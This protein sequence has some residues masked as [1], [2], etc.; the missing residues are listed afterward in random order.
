MIGIEQGPAVVGRSG[1]TPQEASV[2]PN[3]HP[4]EQVRPD[5]HVHPDA[6]PCAA[7]PARGFEPGAEPAVLAGPR[8]A[9]CHGTDVVLDEV[10][11][12]GVLL[13]AECRRCEHRWTSRARPA[14][15]RPRRVAARAGRRAPAAGGAPSGGAASAA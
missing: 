1:G 6:Q 9:V 13:L 11:H 5:P 14:V 7:L 10:F 8:C 15:R 2:M 3:F 4:V 12:G